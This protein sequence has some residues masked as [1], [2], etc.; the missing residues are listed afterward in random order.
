MLRRPACEHLSF[1]IN[2]YRPVK[3]D[4]DHWQPTRRKFQSTDDRVKHSLYGIGSPARHA[5]EREGNVHF[6]S[7]TDKTVRHGQ[8]LAA[9]TQVNKTEGIVGGNNKPTPPATAPLFIKYSG[10][11]ELTGNT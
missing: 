4:R 2:V 9:N 6:P 3:L 7:S 5:K 8:T 10:K 1:Y 11:L